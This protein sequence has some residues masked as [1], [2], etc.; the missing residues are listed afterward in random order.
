[1]D[2]HKILGVNRNATP[3]QIRKAFRKL[4]LKLHPDSGGKKRSKYTVGEIKEAKDLLIEEYHKSRGHSPISD[5][6]QNIFVSDTDPRCLNSRIRYVGS[7][8]KPMVKLKA[9]NTIHTYELDISVADIFKSEYYLHLNNE[10]YLFPARVN[11]GKVNIPDVITTGVRIQTKPLPL[12]KATSLHYTYL[13]INFK[14][15]DYTLNG[16]FR[17][18]PDLS[19]VAATISDQEINLSPTGMAYNVLCPSSDE[20][21]DLI[22]FYVDQ[23]NKLVHFKNKGLPFFNHLTG[24]VENSLLMTNLKTD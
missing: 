7:E 8:H 2:A 4:M 22:P 15:T 10:K 19:G 20:I 6:P 16:L 11:N 18:V 9:T 17:Y 12:E 5:E 21:E 3:V 23:E 14:I 24:E 1:M 13:S